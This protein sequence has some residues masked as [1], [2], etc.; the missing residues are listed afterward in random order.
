M[1]LRKSNKKEPTNQ[2]SKVPVVIYTDN[3]K[4]TVIDIRMIPE[5]KG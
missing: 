2:G 5:K 1:K 3:P 4:V